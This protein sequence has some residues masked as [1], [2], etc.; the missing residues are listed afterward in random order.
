MPPIPG[1]RFWNPSIT[2]D[3]EINWKGLCL[4]LSNWRF[5]WISLLNRF[6]KSFIF[7]VMLLLKQKILKRDF[8][9]VSFLILPFQSL[10][11]MTQF[12]FKSCVGNETR[13]KK[14]TEV[15]NY[16]KFIYNIFGQDTAKIGIIR[17]KVQFSVWV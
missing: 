10:G 8:R 9:E 11:T 1:L 14:L 17:A 2:F 7:L 5:T 4:V 16:G 6:C 15:S 3:H 12:L 13:L